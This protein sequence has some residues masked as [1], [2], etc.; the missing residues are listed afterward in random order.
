[1][2]ETP[3]KCQRILTNIKS[4]ENPTLEV[5]SSYLQKC[6]ILYFLPEDGS[7]ICVYFFSRGDSVDSVVLE[8]CK[9]AYFNRN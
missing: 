1:M 2:G 7:W 3:P 4:S 9:R 5:S 6:G 8:C